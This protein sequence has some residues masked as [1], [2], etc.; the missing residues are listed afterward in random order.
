MDNCKR[1]KVCVVLDSFI[2]PNWVHESLME[3][4]K[5]YDVCLVLIERKSTIKQC[6]KS[7]RGLG[8]RL[9]YK[10]EDVY[11][12]YNRKS[13]L[14]DGTQQQNIQGMVANYPKAN[15]SV[16]ESSLISW[17][18]IERI[19]FVQSGLHVLINLASVTFDKDV[20]AAIEFGV[21]SVWINGAYPNFYWEMS[22]GDLVFEVSQCIENRHGVYWYHSY[23]AVTKDSM[24]QAR[25]SAYWKAHEVLT[26]FLHKCA[27]NGEYFLRQFELRNDP[28]L[29]I[30]E[31]K[32][33]VS[34]QLRLV[35]RLVRWIGYKIFK[36][37]EF[38]LVKE[39]WFIG[40]RRRTG[41]FALDSLSQKSFS[42]LNS[43][44]EKFYADP[45]LFEWNNENYLFYEELCYSKKIGKISCSKLLDDGSLTDSKVVLNKDYH[46]SYPMVFEFEGVIYMIPE[47]ASN[48]T[49]E[50]Y[51]AV[52]FPEV[53]VLEKVLFSNVRA[54][55]TTLYYDGNTYWMFTNIAHRKGNTYDDLHV[56]YAQSPLGEWFPHPLNPVVSDVRK[57][58]P[59]GHLFELGTRL[60]R[61][62]QD[63][64]VR[65][66]HRLMFSEIDVL[67]ET[68]YRER[69]IGF[70][71]PTWRRGNLATHTINYND[72][73][74]VIDGKRLI[75]RGHRNIRR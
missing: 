15:I 65:Y 70:L 5:L 67:S 26:R 44:K 18:S 59:A 19:D 1:L 11:L 39:H 75:F 21:W 23:G 60:I 42:V 14:Q 35:L 64:A 46:L 31:R 45:F 63:C 53:W 10:M 34:L 50:L 32:F 6:K 37:F 29:L 13:L 73:F 7:R 62:A 69:T 27:C 2:V 47:T 41:E 17:E 9:Y 30:S 12:G 66:G 25:S 33:N 51:R 24:F 20:Q 56:F 3:M 38:M 58:R 28:A 8:S 40:I 52:Q 43:G 16:D 55:D 68:D 4:E 48:R 54:V 36:R 22:A 74:A 72:K 57:A 71:N 61:P 49:I